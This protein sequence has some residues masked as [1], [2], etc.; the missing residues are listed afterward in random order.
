MAIELFLLEIMPM[1]GEFPKTSE[2]CYLFYHLSRI[3]PSWESRFS[4]NF[5]NQKLYSIS[6][7][8]LLFAL[9]LA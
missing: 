6:K 3:V 7:N 5:I 2:H 9:N 8:V 4:L 1:Q